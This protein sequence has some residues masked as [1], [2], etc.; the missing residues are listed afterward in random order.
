M[1]ENTNIK[2]I[3]YHKNLFLIK[4]LIKKGTNQKVSILIRIINIYF[5]FFK[6]VN[7]YNQNSCQDFISNSFLNIYQFLK[8]KLNQAQLYHV[9]SRLLF[10]IKDLQHSCFS[11]MDTVSTA[12]SYNPRKYKLYAPLQDEVFFKQ[13]Q[14]CFASCSPYKL[15]ESLIDSK[16]LEFKKKSQEKNKNYLKS[17]I[18]SF[19]NI[20]NDLDKQNKKNFDLSQLSIYQNKQLWKLK[21]KTHNNKSLLWIFR[22]YWL[23]FFFKVLLFKTI[24]SL[25]NKLFVFFFKKRTK[26]VFFKRLLSKQ[27]YKKYIQTSNCMGGIK[28]YGGAK[29]SKISEFN[30]RKKLLSKRAPI[31]V[32][33]TSFCLCS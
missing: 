25:N 16:Y 28:D 21:K 7:D 33:N 22:K 2:K 18:K 12:Y 20:K 29:K 32:L 8:F 27:G 5:R 10:T 30:L 14:S 31:L 6:S 9:E 24:S 13:Q 4:N 26:T 1:I 19:L 23:N 11:I 15:K 3:L 17:F